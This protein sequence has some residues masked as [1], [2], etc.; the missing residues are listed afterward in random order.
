VAGIRRKKRQ[1]RFPNTA[2]RRDQQKKKEKKKK[3]KIEHKFRV[4][5]NALVGIAGIRSEDEGRDE[6]ICSH[7]IFR[8]LFVLRKVS[9]ECFFLDWRA[10][11]GCFG[12]INRAVEV[13]ISAILFPA[14]ND[15]H[16]VQKRK[17]ETKKISER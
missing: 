12:M 8:V 15:H 9:F 13:E 4:L 16:L 3:K 11:L 2:T 10:Y 7:V 6:N 14:G 5:T 17:T 1:V